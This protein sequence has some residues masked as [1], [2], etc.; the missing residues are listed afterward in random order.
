MIIFM[1][2]LFSNFQEK[3]N[4]QI[5]VIRQI[6]ASLHIDSQLISTQSN[7][8]FIGGRAELKQINF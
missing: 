3:E 7:P 4:S 5:S 2:K 6:I 8:R 1:K